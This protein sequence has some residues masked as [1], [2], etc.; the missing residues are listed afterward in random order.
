MSAKSEKPMLSKLENMKEQYKEVWNDFNK[1][2]KEEKD[3]GKW[4]QS[5]RT[6]G[7]ADCL[8]QIITDLGEIIEEFK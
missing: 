6:R 7:Y 3:A 8:S 5:A 2:W 1:E 4:G